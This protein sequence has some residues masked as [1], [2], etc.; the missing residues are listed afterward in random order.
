VATD[1]FEEIQGS[2]RISVKIVEGNTGSAV[3][4]WLRGGVH[5]QLRFQ[6]CDELVYCVSIP[7]VDLVMYES[8]DRSLQP[9]L[10]PTRVSSLTEEDCALVIVQTV[11][12]I[13]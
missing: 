2:R 13:G 4:R 12:T 10:I 9:P 5:N 8:L 3:V 11:Y 6:L 7:D 1:G